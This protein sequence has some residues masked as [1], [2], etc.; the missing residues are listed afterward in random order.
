MPQMQCVDVHPSLMTDIQVDDV[1]PT[2]PLLE[3]CWMISPDEVNMEMDL[4]LSLDV[5]T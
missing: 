5:D 2:A 4:P 3:G 1:T